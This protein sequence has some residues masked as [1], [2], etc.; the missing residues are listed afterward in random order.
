[1]LADHGEDVVEA[2]VAVEGARRWIWGVGVARTP[3]PPDADWKF[4]A[5]FWTVCNDDGYSNQN[6]RELFIGEWTT[7]EEAVVRFDRAARRVTVAGPG[8]RVYTVAEGVAP[9]CKLVVCVTHGSLK[10][11]DFR[12]SGGRR[13]A[14]IVAAPAAPQCSL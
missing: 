6:G 10:V 3:L 8:G 2:R 11:L 5:G 4:G 14:A 9:D 13:C 1:M 12:C 7:L